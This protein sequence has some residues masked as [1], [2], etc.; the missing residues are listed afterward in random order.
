MERD[1]DRGVSD[2]VDLSFQGVDSR[3]DAGES[4]RHRVVYPQ[5]RI[6]GP[7]LWIL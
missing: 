2:I 4:N 7:R 3:I 6:L 5:D 1:E